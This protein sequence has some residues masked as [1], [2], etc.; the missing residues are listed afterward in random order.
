MLKW[1]WRW[2]S[3]HEELPSLPM[4]K[5]LH[6]QPEDRSLDANTGAHIWPLNCRNSPPAGKRLRAPAVEGWLYVPD[7]R[8]VVVIDT[9]TTGLGR[10]DRIVSIGAVILSADELLPISVH[11]LVFNPGRPSHPIA[12]R[13]HGLS[14]EFLGRQPPF[15]AHARHIKSLLKG[16]VVAAHNL[17]FDLRMLNQEFVAAGLPRYGSR[18]GR[19]CTME[20][21]RFRRPG[22]SA[23]LAAVSQALGLPK[24]PK[25]HGALEDAALVAMVL[26]A[27]H[28]Y[29]FI[30]SPNIHGVGFENVL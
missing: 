26:Q 12:Q 9:E 24:Q 28:G 8:E 4:A 18:S 27:M 19:Y 3:R 7:G 25:V 5:A 21:W 15:A 17:V 11:S 22:A 6:P 1:F 13:V 10:D 14:D 2:L 20:E 16:R 23:K 29:N 30:I